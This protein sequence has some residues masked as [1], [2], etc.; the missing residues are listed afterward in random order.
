MHDQSTIKIKAWKRFRSDDIVN[1]CITV[2]VYKNCARKISLCFLF[3]TQIYTLSKIDLE[4]V[5]RI[6]TNNIIRRFGV[7]HDSI[8]DVKL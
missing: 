1:Y 4:N 7:R 5:L 3:A 8:I 2:I 6:K